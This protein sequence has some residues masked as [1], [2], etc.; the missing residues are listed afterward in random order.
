MSIF[1]T[2]FS[3]G[4]KPKKIK[5][6][7]QSLYGQRVTIDPQTYNPALMQAW[8]PWA[9]RAGAT[10]GAAADQL[11]AA[12]ADNKLYGEL[13]T[14]ASNDLAL[15][16]DLSPDEIRAAQQAGL[17]SWSSRGLTRS[18]QAGFAAVLSRL[19]YANQRKDARQGFAMGVANLGLQRQQAATSALGT[20]SQAAA[21]PLALAEDS[22]QTEVAR[23][24]TLRFND[25]RIAA[26]IR[27]GDQ[28]AQAGKSAAK[29]SAFGS[30]IGGVLGF[31]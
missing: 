8:A 25:K 21:I 2:T 13:S 18:P 4:A 1:G 11:S 20:A 6:E 24:D 7:E 3:Q 19:Q 26:D 12:G 31:L 29:T 10:A 28:N 15:G 9:A 14:R 16:G 30:I 5:P 27:I 23:D 22:R 17:A